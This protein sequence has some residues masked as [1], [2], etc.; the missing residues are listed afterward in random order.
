MIRQRVFRNS[1]DA[2]PKTTNLPPKY[3][4]ECV[5]LQRPQYFGSGALDHGHQP[6]ALWAADITIGAKL[7]Q[8]LVSGRR[9]RCL[10]MQDRRLGRGSQY[11][12][13][14]DHRCD[15]HGCRAARAWERR[16]HSD[17]GSQYTQ[18]ASGLRC[19]ED[20][21]RSSMGS[22]GDSIRQCD[23]RE[24]LRH[25]RMRVARPEQVPD[26]G[27][28]PHGGLRVHRGM[29]QSRPAP[30]GARISIAHSLRKETG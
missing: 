24:L 19:R 25:A 3:F 17:Q 22:V 16:S 7:G 9:S 4:P 23:E 14:I 12:V 20:C 30:F 28:G 13:S 5:M 1:A 2:Q 26:Q 27:R 10:Q 18:V 15:E 6:N 8:L 29:V 21:V 11:Q